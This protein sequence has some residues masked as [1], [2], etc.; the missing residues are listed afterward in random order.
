MVLDQSASTHKT[1]SRDPYIGLKGKQ[2]LL[3][4]LPGFCSPPGTHL[5]KPHAALWHASHTPAHASHILEAA[6]C[7]RTSSQKL[8]HGKYNTAALLIRPVWASSWSKVAQGRLAPGM[9]CCWLKR[10]C[11]IGQQRKAHH[12][13]NCCR[14]CGRKQ[15]LG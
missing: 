9:S 15:T 3:H 5:H 1:L 12:D 7:W 8:Q 10:G 2:Q 6:S 14:G 13:C 4:V 11:S